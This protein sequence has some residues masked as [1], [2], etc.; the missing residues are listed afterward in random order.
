LVAE[1]LVE[2]MIIELELKNC[3]SDIDYHMVIMHTVQ[4]P[5]TNMIV[6]LSGQFYYIGK[7]TIIT[8]IK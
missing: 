6:L 3:N 8:S 1:V 7:G 4:C 5:L 2:A